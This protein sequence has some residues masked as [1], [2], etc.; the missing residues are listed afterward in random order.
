MQKMEIIYSDKEDNEIFIE[1]T[2]V[3][4]DDYLASILSENTT[5]E[6]WDGQN[7]YINSYSTGEQTISYKLIKNDIFI[8]ISTG[9]EFDKNDVKMII[10]KA[11]WY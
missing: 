3:D 4:E 2:K 11:A 10:Q 1:Q 7:V 8:K 9:P 5:M 6:T